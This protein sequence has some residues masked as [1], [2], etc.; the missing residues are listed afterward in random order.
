MKKTLAALFG[1][2]TLVAGAAAADTIVT[3]LG[4]PI[5]GVVTELPDGN[6]KVTAGERVLVYRKEE[7]VSIE[8]NSKTGALDME[9]IKA[10]A[11]K[12]DQELTEKTG[13]TASQRARVDALMPSLMGEGSAHIQ[14]RDALV[15]MQAECNVFAYLK[16]L[17]EEGVPATQIAAYEVLLRIDMPNALETVRAGLSNSNSSVREKAIELLGQISSVSDAPLIARGL[18]DPEFSVRIATAYSLANLGYRA[19]TPA[20]IE[21]LPHPD[22]RVSNAAREALGQLWKD[23]LGETKPA[24]VDEWTA[25]WEANKGGNSA[26]ALKDLEPLSDP[27]TPFVAG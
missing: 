13:L 6:Y 20:L 24:T 9:A 21:S 18:V 14:A 7:I 27:A 3:D 22:L 10:A 8:K 12:A 5:D 23:S 25:V 1:A 15:A 17:C 2:Y 4:V 11:M 16:M 19:A 26:V